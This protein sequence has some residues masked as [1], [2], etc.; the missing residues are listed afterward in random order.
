M[1]NRPNPSQSLAASI[2]RNSSL[3]TYYTIRLLVDRE[4]VPDAYRA[5]AYFRWV[6]DLLDGELGSASEKASFLQR[7][8]SLLDACYHGR[9]TRDLCEEEELLLD[10]VRSDPSPTSGLHAYLYGMIEVM[11]FDVSRR[12]RLITQFELADYSRLLST[13]VTEA[14]YYFIDHDKPVPPH[15][16]RFLS[17]TAAH[18]IH[19]LRDAYEDTEAGYYNLPGEFLHAHAISPWNLQSRAFR[20]WVQERV[21]LALYYFE[22][23]RI[24]ISHDCSFRRRLAGCAYIARFEWM[25]RCIQ[26]DGYCL[27]PEY[28]NRKSLPAALWMLRLIL[29]NAFPISRLRPGPRKLAA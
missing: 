15:D 11:A 27:R 23:G 22:A 14:I 28:A 20:Q 2:T 10:L 4:R 19:M 6:D 26:H 1:N 7:Q 21:R 13:A 9:I 24:C 16:A 5:Y 18:I 25:L 12:G 17:V 29:A 8:R 3:Q